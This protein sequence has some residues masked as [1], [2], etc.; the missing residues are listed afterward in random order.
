MV[1]HRTTTDH[2]GFFLGVYIIII[3]DLYSVA[4]RRTDNNM[5][6]VFGTP[7]GSAY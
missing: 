7:K 4:V 3:F 1:I 6:C 5:C 2:K